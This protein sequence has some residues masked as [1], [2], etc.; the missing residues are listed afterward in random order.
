MSLHIC[1]SVYLPVNKRSFSAFSKPIFHL[2]SGSRT[3]LFQFSPLWKK[4]SITC[5]YIL[6][7]PIF[8]KYSSSLDLIKTKVLKRYVYTNDI[9]LFILIHSSTHS[10]M[11]PTQQNPIPCHFSTG[12]TLIIVTNYVSMFPKLIPSLSSSYW[13]SCQHSNSVDS[14]LLLKTLSYLLVSMCSKILFV[15]LITLSQS[16][17]LL[18]TWALKHYVSRLSSPL[19]PHRFPRLPSPQYGFQHYSICKSTTPKFISQ[20]RPLSPDSQNQLPTQHLIP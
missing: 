13:T 6:L 5:K 1:K 15:L 10:H 20:L 12:M 3:L 7:K 14:S 9:N 4:I 2:C 16:S 19:T 18:L 8:W 17:L 11:I